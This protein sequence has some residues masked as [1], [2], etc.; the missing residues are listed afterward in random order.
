MKGR[1]LL[2]LFLWLMALVLFITTCTGALAHVKE[3]ENV[4]HPQ[5]YSDDPVLLVHFKANDKVWQGRLWSGILLK[6]ANFT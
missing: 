6:S 5:E 1:N 2:T 3:H 4:V